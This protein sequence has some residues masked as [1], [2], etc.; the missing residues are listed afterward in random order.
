M[1]FQTSRGQEALRAQIR[2]F[3]E[4]EIRPQAFLMDQ[5][6]EFPEEAIRKLGERGWMGLPYPSEYGG[7]GLDVMSYAIAVE[8]LA[9]VDGGPS[10]MPDQMPAGR[11]RQRS[12]KET[13]G[14]STAVKFLSPMRRK[15]ILMSSSR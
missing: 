6:N 2:Q 13:T 3:A 1:L 10:R 9:R 8:E 11:K 14:C 7:A 12:T 5:N 15:R 4:E